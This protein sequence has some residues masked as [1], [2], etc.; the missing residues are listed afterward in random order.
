MKIDVTPML[1]HHR[2]SIDRCFIDV[3]PIDPKVNWMQHRW[4]TNRRYTGV[5]P[6]WGIVDGPDWQSMHS[7]EFTF[8]RKHSKMVIHV[9]AESPLFRFLMG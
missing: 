6:M 2:C 1:I 5:P 9:L 8:V 4:S 7:S 3:T